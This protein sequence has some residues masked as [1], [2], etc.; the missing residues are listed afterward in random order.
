MQLRV[1]GVLQRAFGTSLILAFDNLTVLFH[2]TRTPLSKAYCATSFRI[3][4]VIRIGDG[5][6]TQDKA[7][8]RAKH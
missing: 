1:E 5:L 3:A 8:R 7:V 6:K 2:F 4:L